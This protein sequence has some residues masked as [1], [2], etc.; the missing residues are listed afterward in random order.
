MLLRHEDYFKLSTDDFYYNGDV[1][2]SCIL[3]LFQTVAS[4]HAEKLGM[5]FDDMIKKDMIW[6]LVKIRLDVVDKIPFT[7]TVK[8]VTYPHPKGRLGYVRD[9]LIYDENGNLTVKGSALWC[10]VSYSTRK[11]LRPTIDYEGEYVDSKIYLDDFIRLSPI[12]SQNHSYVCHILQTD[13]DRNNHTNN[14]K[15]ADFIINGL[16][17]IP[18]IKSFSIQFN[19]E[20]KLGDEI[21]L[22]Y[23]V[24]EKEI[25]ATATC[26]D[27]NAFNAQIIIN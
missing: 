20:T 9:Y 7:S 14:V 17:E 5:G 18:N 15:Y 27:K 2:L 12:L 16:N 13:I 6:V 23:D 25:N 24:Q 4:D 1:K 21:N 3:N 26:N 22:A 11:L 19:H 8:V 10:F